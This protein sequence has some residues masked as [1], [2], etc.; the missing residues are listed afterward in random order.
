MANIL[1]LLD[2]R[3]RIEHSLVDEATLPG[4]GIYRKVTHPERGEVLEE[5]GSLAGIDVIV[6][7]RHLHDNP[8]CTDMRPLD[9]NTEIVVA[10]APSAGTYQHI[11]LAFGK[12]LAVDALYIVSH[13]IIVHRREMVVVLH[14]HYIHDILADTMTE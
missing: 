4:I 10:G 12:E 5:M 14:I 9:G 3:H 8:G 1:C 6:L 7:Q 13:I 2:R 11:V